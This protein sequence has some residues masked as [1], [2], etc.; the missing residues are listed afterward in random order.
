MSK[1][2]HPKRK[3]KSSSSSGSLFLNVPKELQ[4]IDELVAEGDLKEA[5][6]ALQ[7][8]TERAPHR[9]EI[10]E[11]MLLLGT[12]WKD[13][14][15]CLEGAMRLVKLRPFAAV[16]HYNLFVVYLKNSF[17]ALAFKTATEFLKRW[18]DHKLGK[19]LPTI[20]EKLRPRLLDEQIVAN[21]S[22]ERRLEMLALHDSSLLAMTLMNFE[23]C[24]ESATQLIQL[25]PNFL[26]AYNNRSFAHWA[27]GNTDAAL[28]D[29]ERA[30]TL[31]PENIHALFAK[32][33]YSVLSNRL[34]EARAI[35]EKLKGIRTNEPDLLIKQAEAFAYLFDDAAV[36]EI[37]SRLE[38][39]K[40]NPLLVATTHLFAGVAAARLGET[41]RARTF[42]NEV[43]K[44]SVVAQRAEV[45]LADL[46]KP[47]G[48]RENARAFLLDHWIPRR[49]VKELVQIFED[50]ARH[51]NL[52]TSQRALQK[53]LAARPNLAPLL[54]KMLE[55]GDEMT[56]RL[57][58]QIAE[59]ANLP[60]LWQ[61]LKDFAGSPHGPDRFRNEVLFALQNAG[62]YE[63]GQRVPFWSAG[64]LIE[65]T[66]HRYTIDN[67][68]YDANPSEHVVRTLLAAMLAHKQDDFEREVAIL[69]AALE[70]EPNSATL[71][72]QLVQTYLQQGRVAAAREVAE[73]TSVQHSN[74]ALP[75][76]LLAMIA[77]ANERNDEVEQHINILT[78][79]EHFQHEEYA[80][81]CRVQMIYQLLVK[82]DHDGA[83][84]WFE[85][86]KKR[87]AR[88]LDL[89]SA[90]EALKSRVASK[91]WARQLLSSYRET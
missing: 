41:A 87:S 34:A 59:L 51:A 30:L 83:R 45:Q 1:S 11:T 31:E 75:R 32:V 90:Q 57:A 13:L 8:L 72:I 78:A 49:V 54:P 18:P 39:D 56:R 69:S 65:V 21:F 48:Q 89:E 74:F 66:I 60:E 67:E 28:A 71:Q 44:H 88:T 7:D 76:I 17:P 10:F 42:F 25:E 2:R 36:L 77:L 52:Q 4:R 15:L 84:Q 24:L 82:S 35:A 22:E 47:E 23:H 64:K 6:A 79:L 29:S 33:R 9:A 40:G 86:W 37:V 62:Q 55:H 16:D 3:P 91:Q 14:A 61:I 27:M 12:Q 80:Q 50:G 5:V 20:L 68:P 46:D 38:G 70:E 19:E 43:R 63:R 53:F 58:F 81:F 73:K 85:F 26:P